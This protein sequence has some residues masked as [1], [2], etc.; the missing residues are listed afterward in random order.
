[1]SNNSIPHRQHLS[2]WMLIALVTGNMI[3]SGIFLL[4]SALANFGTISLLSWVF[5]SFGALMIALVFA[6][7]SSVMPRAGG[8]YAYCREAYGEF[9]GF[10]VAYNYW[11]TLWVGGSA[12]AVAF[13]SYLGFF[14]PLLLSNHLAAFFVSAGAVWVMTIINIIG[15]RHAGI[16]QLITTILKLLPLLLVGSL[17]LLFIQKPNLAQF[18]ISG[19]SNFS[20]LSGAATLTL[21][22]FIGLEA[23]T[24]PAENVSNPHRTIPMA[25][26]IGV[27]ITAVVYLL[28]TFAVMGIVPVEKL[29][30]SSA[31]FAEAATVIFG[32]LGA[33]LVAAGAVLS[34]LGALN[35]WVLLQGQIPMAAA[36]DEIFPKQFA[37]KSRFGT[38]VVGLIFTSILMTLLLLSTVG[39][40]LVQQFTFIVLLATFASLIPY[41]FTTVAQFIFFI[42]KGRAAAAGGKI[43]LNIC[44]ATLATIYSIWAFFG[45]GKVIFFY[46]SLLF[47]TGVPI[48]AVMKFSKVFQKRSINIEN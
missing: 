37:Y 32:P 27:L 39:F 2:L 48:Y 11:I 44:I 4:P 8:P 28:S 42:R 7:L 47:L 10:Q 18:N 25:T 13:A 41:L 23:A 24:I 38:P 12:I 21:W 40:G 16:F 31:P 29:A 30:H 43:I 26:I 15:V 5:T 14:W 22:A 3:G 19:L 46:G 17:G 33:V 34:C 35:G 1:M 20:A 6:N 9:L 45:A 36:R